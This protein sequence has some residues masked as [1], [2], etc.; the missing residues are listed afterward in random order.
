[1]AGLD[2]VVEE[3][4]SS[5]GKRKVIVASEDGTERIVHTI[6][7]SQELREDIEEGME[8]GTTTRLTEGSIDPQQL[9]EVSGIDRRAGW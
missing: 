5:D 4:R 9:L 3:I 1:M 7:A 8:V 6:P 2:G